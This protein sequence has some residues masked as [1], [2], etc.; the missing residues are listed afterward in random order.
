MTL[1]IEV[2]EDR[3]TCFA[4]RHTVFVEEQGVPIEEEIDEL[5]EVAT[6]I[7]AT[8]DGV[9]TGAARIVFDAETAKIGR[10]CVLPKGR[11]TGMGVA[12]IQ[13]GVEIARAK[14]GVTK[15]KLGAQIHALGFYEKLGFQAYGP[16]YD[17]AGIDH[18]D[19]MLDLA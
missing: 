17:D 5:D 7:L 4:L 16:V 13:K 3:D 1:K 2:T 12:L 15:V 19:M 9:P 8:A 14:P 18:R 11:G 10:V 6:H